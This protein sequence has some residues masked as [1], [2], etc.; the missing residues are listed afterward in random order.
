MWYGDLNSSCICT[1]KIYYLWAKTLVYM[2]AVPFC[3][4]CWNFQMGNHRRGWIH[5]SLLRGTKPPSAHQ[6]SRR[7][8]VLNCGRHIPVAACSICCVEAIS[9][10]RHGISKLYELF[11]KRTGW[12]GKDCR[13][14]TQRFSF[15]FTLQCFCRNITKHLEILLYSIQIH[16]IVTLYIVTLIYTLIH[17]S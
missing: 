11:P 17:T 13:L 8:M 4:A 14:Q 15:S 6:V 16:L 9:V 1:R 3:C 5:V 12:N 2:V 10:H 7:K